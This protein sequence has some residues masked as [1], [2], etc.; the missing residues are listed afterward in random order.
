MS[1]A[2][3]FALYHWEFATCPRIMAGVRAAV[4]NTFDSL[5]RMHSIRNYEI[6]IIE[7]LLESGN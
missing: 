1:V 4:G 6:I 2:E 5:V 7:L 3:L